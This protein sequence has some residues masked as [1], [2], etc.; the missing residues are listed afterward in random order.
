MRPKARHTAH[1]RPTTIETDSNRHIM[2]TTML[3]IWFVGTIL[4]LAAIYAMLRVW[5]APED[6]TTTNKKPRGG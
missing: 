4:S 2:A 5:Y 1:S 6:E 3:V